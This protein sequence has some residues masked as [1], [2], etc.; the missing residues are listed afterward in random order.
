MPAG[1]SSTPLL[2]KLGYRAGQRAL[3]VGLPPEPAELAGF[4]G[5]VRRETRPRLAGLDVAGPFDL[6]HV[7][8]RDR[9]RLAAGLSGLRALLDPAGMIWVSWPRKAAKQPT[10]LTEDIVRELALARGLVDVKVCAID[11][12]WSGLKLVIPRAFRPKG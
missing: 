6:I 1:Y 5:F 10:T 11:A 2:A 4:T 7:F 9:D 3:L 8:E 12:V